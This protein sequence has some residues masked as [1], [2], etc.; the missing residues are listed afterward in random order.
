MDRVTSTNA[1][2][3]LLWS[4]ENQSDHNQPRLSRRKKET[5]MNYVPDW[6]SELEF[7][8]FVYKMNEEDAARIVMAD[9][10]DGSSEHFYSKDGRS[11]SISA[12][13]QMQLPANG[14]IVVSDYAKAAKAAAQG[15]RIQKKHLESPVFVAAD[16][17]L[18]DGNHRV[19]SA[20]R[21]GITELPAVFLS[22]E[23]DRLA[24]M[25]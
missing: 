6:Q 19:L 3:V 18:I 17:T 5:E 23:Q 25:K 13:R 14:H 8:T 2:P 24:R 15:K 10:L 12:V 20:A 9:W 4:G 16:G 22:E 1:V 11:W 21:R 7:H